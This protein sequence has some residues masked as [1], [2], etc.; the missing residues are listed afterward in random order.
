MDRRRES[1]VCESVRELDEFDEGGR[2]ACRSWVSVCVVGRGR[3]APEKRSSAQTN[4]PR[5]ALAVNR[6]STLDAPPPDRRE[7]APRHCCF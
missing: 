4:A 5:F 7:S 6:C 1:E 2:S 3:G